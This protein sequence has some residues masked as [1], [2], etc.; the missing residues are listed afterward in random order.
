MS[1]T[2][3]IPIAFPAY[4]GGSFLNEASL[5]YL[6]S[7][8]SRRRRRLRP[9]QASSRSAA[10]PFQIVQQK[11]SPSQQSEPHQHRLARRP[12]QDGG[13]AA[14]PDYRVGTGPNAVRNSGS[15]ATIAAPDDTDVSTSPS[16]PMCAAAVERGRHHQVGLFI[17][18]GGK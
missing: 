1:T 17:Q 7:D 11:D 13:P 6:N 8:H 3:S 9:D 2:A 16:R 18:D 15:S 12:R 10:A 5:D 14:T 4:T